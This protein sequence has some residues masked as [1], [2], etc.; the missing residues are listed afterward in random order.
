M[1]EAVTEANIRAAATVHSRAWQSSHGF[2]APD[3]VAAHT[4]ERQEAY[5]RE[6][7]RAGSR[8]YLLSE[9]EPV[10]LVSVTGSLIADLYI[11]P[12]RQNQG[13]G[14]ALLR[15]AVAR[16]EG[17][18]TLWILETNHGAERLYRREGFKPTGKRKSLPNGPDEIEFRLE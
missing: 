17:T 3:F 13:R 8:V 2:C 1:I 18:P 6:K 16:C 10:G 11:L 4:P 5:L 12:E 14:T 7:L 15:Y 9:E